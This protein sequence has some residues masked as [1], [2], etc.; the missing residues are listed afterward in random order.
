MASV[1]LKRERGG[2]RYCDC[3]DIEKVIEEV[4]P[5]LTMSHPYNLHWQSASYN[6]FPPCLCKVNLARL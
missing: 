1:I 6:G 3:S 2:V 5:N 4:V